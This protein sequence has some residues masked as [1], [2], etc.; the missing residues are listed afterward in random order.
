MCICNVDSRQHVPKD[1]EEEKDRFRLLLASTAVWDP[2]AGSS[3][4]NW[5]LV[6]QIL[7]FVR[8]MI[9]RIGRYRQAAASRIDYTRRITKNQSCVRKS[10]KEETAWFQ[11]SGLLY[12]AKERKWNPEIEIEGENEDSLIYGR[13]MSARQ[14]PVCVTLGLAAE[15]K[16]HSPFSRSNRKCSVG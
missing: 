12:G 3:R 10:T 5:N 13:A 1:R 16:I 7:S 15:V 11:S 9:R 2:L 8:R 4:K 6:Q 14:M